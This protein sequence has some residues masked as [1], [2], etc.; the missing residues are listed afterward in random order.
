MTIYSGPIELGSMIWHT[1]SRGGKIV[2][3]RIEGKTF[4][5]VGCPQAVY[6]FMH[7]GM[8]VRLYMQYFPFLG[9]FILGVKDRSR[10][11]RMMPRFYEVIASCIMAIVLLAVA[12]V[13]P[14]GL[15]GMYL[16]AVKATLITCCVMVPLLAA[17]LIFFGYLQ[18]QADTGK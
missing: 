16:N 6:D 5:R 1:G 18:A 11:L 15:I 17:T 10:Q 13:I 7:N 9:H 4:Q 3:L 8:D 2:Y 14:A 12:F